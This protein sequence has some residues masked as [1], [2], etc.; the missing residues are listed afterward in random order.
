CCHRCFAPFPANSAC[1]RVR[2]IGSGDRCS[3]LSSERQERSQWLRLV[4][5]RVLQLVGDK[6]N[7][8]ESSCLSR[9]S[10]CLLLACSFPLGEMPPA[11][12]IEQLTD[13]EDDSR[14]TPA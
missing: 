13:F 11:R 7:I 1:F 10:G 9:S 8:G 6:L 3:E 2:N 4:G 14:C 5:H 12:A